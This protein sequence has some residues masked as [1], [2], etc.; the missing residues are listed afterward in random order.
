[1][2]SLRVAVY[3]VYV[4]LIIIYEDISQ[5]FQIFIYSLNSFIG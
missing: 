4:S 3:F 2:Q 1:M 5:D